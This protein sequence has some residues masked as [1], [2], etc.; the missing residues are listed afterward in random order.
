M[1]GQRRT[2]SGYSSG[3][4]TA[5]LVHNTTSDIPLVH[6]THVDQLM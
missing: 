1:S 2:G 6:V 3:T 4:C 5:V